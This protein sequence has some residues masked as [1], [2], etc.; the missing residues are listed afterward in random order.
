MEMINGNNVAPIETKALTR[1]VAELDFFGNASIKA[2]YVPES[3]NELAI[4]ATIAKIKAR[5]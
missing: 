4:P 1:T 2:G 5:V 3:S